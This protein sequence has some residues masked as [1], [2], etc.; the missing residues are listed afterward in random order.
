MKAWSFL[1]LWSGLLALWV[2]S[3]VPQYFE[4]IERTHHLPASFNNQFILRNDSGGKGHFGASRNGGRRHNGIDLL[5]ELGAPVYASKSGRVTFVGTQGGYGNYIRLDHPDG[6]NTRYAHLTEARVKM[7]QWAWRGQLIGTVGKTGN[8][9]GPSIL[10]H[11]H[12]EIRR[13]EEPI[14]PTHQLDTPLAGSTAQWD[15]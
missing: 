9:D 15:G 6:T 1:T 13:Q 11:L 14:D 7:G 12:Y 3:A 4:Y 8:A 2:F 5:S 10:P